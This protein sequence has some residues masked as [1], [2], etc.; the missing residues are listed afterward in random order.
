MAGRINPNC[1]GQITDNMGRCVGDNKDLPPG[2]YLLPDG[3]PITLYG[4]GRSDYEN[5]NGISGL[6]GRTWELFLSY[7]EMKLNIGSHFE[8]DAS[9]VFTGTPTFL[10]HAMRTAFFLM[11]A[12]A[13]GLQKLAMGS[14]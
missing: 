11:L 6:S 2:F 13:P 7:K 14:W 10:D 4:E 1:P 12:P 9:Q 5:G 8:P 3:I